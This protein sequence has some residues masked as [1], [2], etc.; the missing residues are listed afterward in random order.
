M[1]LIGQRKVGDVNS[2]GESVMPSISSQVIA[3]KLTARARRE[4]TLQYRR[5]LMIFILV[6]S[7]FSCVRR[8]KSILRMAMYESGRKILSCIMVLLTD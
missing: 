3:L 5:G 1:S 2:H 4:K 6:I 8:V 7:Y